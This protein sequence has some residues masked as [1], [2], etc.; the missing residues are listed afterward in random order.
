M[1][2]RVIL[3]NH[4]ALHSKMKLVPVHYIVSMQ[5]SNMSMKQQPRNT[6]MQLK[7]T[8]ILRDAVHVRA[9]DQTYSGSSANQTLTID[10]ESSTIS[11]SVTPTSPEVN[12]AATVTV[13]LQS[14]GPGTPGI[15]RRSITL[16]FDNGA[17]A[18]YF[19]DDFG[20]LTI[21]HTF[22]IVRPATITA[23]FGGKSVRS[24]KNWRVPA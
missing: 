10:R 4:N 7:G 18:T 19:T 12:Q 2:S 15:A 16:N 5:C 24:C 23:S 9:G 21:T 1:S 17:N 6:V 22:T 8:Q 14:G 3:S 20:V 11:I 13:L